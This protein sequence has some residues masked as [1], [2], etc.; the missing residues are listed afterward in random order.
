MGACLS[1]S[2][3]MVVDPSIFVLDGYYIIPTVSKTGARAFVRIDPKSKTFNVLRDR[4][5]S[6]INS[7]NETTINETTIN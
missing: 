1:Q 5:M 3:H 6:S 2:Q 4:D 7:I